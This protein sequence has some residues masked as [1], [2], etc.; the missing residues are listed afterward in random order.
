V[1][2]RERF[3]SATVAWINLR[4]AP[5]NVPIS[6]DTPLFENRLID[7]LKILKLM[8]WTER[9]IGRRITDEQIRMDNFATVRRIAETFIGEDEQHVEC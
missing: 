4:L 7:S 3:T 5:A 8:A 6:A 2:A 9:A 1:S